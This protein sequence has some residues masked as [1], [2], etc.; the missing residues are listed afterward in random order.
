MSTNAIDAYYS[1]QYQSQSLLNQTSDG[2]STSATGSSSGSSNLGTRYNSVSSQ[3]QSLLA[4]VPK[5]GD[6]L[7]FQDI[8]DY[9]DK[10]QDQFEAQARKDLEA[11]GVDVDLDFALSYDAASDTVTASSSHPDKAIID[12]YFAGN[13]DMRDLFGQVVSYTNLLDPVE[14][15]LTPSQIST[16]LRADSMRLWFEENS[17]SSSFLGGY[18]NLLFKATTQSTEYFGVNLKV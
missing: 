1:M 12:K 16:Q 17:D 3:V 7:T 15:K 13:S 14:T 2:T 18:G 4:D 5:S 9:R 8:I 6:K 10:L 11:L